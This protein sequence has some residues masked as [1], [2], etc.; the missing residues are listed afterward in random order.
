[1]QN[2]LAVVIDTFQGHPLIHGF[3]FGRVT[4]DWIAFTFYLGIP[5][6]AFV[7]TLFA[8][9]GNWWQVSLLTWFV[10]ILA[11]MALFALCELWFEAWACLELVD[12]EEGGSEDGAAGRDG[13]WMARAAHWSRVACR[14]CV[15]TCSYRLSGTHVEFKKMDEKNAVT[16]LSNTFFG[17]V[18]R[19]SQGP[20]SCLANRGWCPCCTTR[21]GRERVRDLDEVLGNASYVTRGSWS[22]ERLF[23]RSTYS[24]SVIPVTRGESSITEAQINSNIACGVL[25]NLII[26]LLCSAVLVWLDLTSAALTVAIILIIACSC[27]VGLS[28]YRL[29]GIRDDI[30]NEESA[31]LYRYYELYQ[32]SV[33]VEG[34]T[35]T[36]ICLEVVFFF[37]LPL[38]QLAA[39]R[40]VQS[41][42]VRTHSSGVYS[43]W[44]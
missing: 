42:T 9:F 21:E 41:A 27:C 14:A 32:H 22:L 33:P 4:T 34:F 10:S 31:T 15:R 24:T 5:L 43:Y 40:N 3:G 6:V 7:V 1:M 19:A 36:I 17:L 13:P 2:C 37:L 44:G 8:R 29:V 25:G 28:T 39:R 16:D 26:I 35:W 11:F 12:E 38:I 18:G 23:C 30:V 20:Y